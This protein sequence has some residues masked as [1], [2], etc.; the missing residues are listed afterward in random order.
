MGERDMDSSWGKL[1]DGSLEREPRFANRRPARTPRYAAGPRC[2]SRTAHEFVNK[3][4]SGQG[5][6]ELEAL[7]SLL[8]WKPAAA[9]CFSHF[10]WGFSRWRILTFARECRPSKCRVR[11]SNG[12]TAAV[13]PILSSSRWSAKSMPSWR[14]HGT[15]TANSRKAPRHPQG[16]ARI[17]RSRTT[18]SRSTGSPR[19]TPSSPRNAATTIRSDTPA[20]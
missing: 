15:P 7:R 6:S 14:S 3:K 13:T 20:S 10:S 8:C 4:P 19:G 18:T 9:L 2:Y 17:C 12:D 5:I 1:I 11:N 16:R